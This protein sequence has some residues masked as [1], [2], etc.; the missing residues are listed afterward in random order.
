MFQ[1]AILESVFFSWLRFLDLFKVFSFNFYHI[2]PYSKSPFFT[3]IWQRIY[4]GNFFPFPSSRVEAN[5]RIDSNFC[6]TDSRNRNPKNS[7]MTHPGLFFGSRIPQT[8]VSVNRKTV[9]AILLA[10]RPCVDHLSSHGAGKCFP[11]RKVR[12]TR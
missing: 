3:T 1:C 11:P 10:P 5:P 6:A 9:F 2:D 8:T 7:R 4:H 12:A